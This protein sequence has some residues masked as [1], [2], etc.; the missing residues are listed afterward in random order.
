MKGIQHLTLNIQQAAPSTQ[1]PVSNHDLGSALIIY[2]PQPHLSALC[3]NT[4]LKGLP[5]HHC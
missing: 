5:Y 1:Y 2:L 4:L 3:L